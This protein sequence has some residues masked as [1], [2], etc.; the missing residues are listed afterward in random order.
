MPPALIALGGGLYYNSPPVFLLA[1][2]EPR[3]AKIH[4]EQ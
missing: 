2:G 1:F 3:E 4:K